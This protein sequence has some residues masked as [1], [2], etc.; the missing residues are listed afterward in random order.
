[1]KKVS[2]VFLSVLFLSFVKKNDYKIEILPI[3]FAKVLAITV[4]FIFL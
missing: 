1:M 4:S 3:A 2:D